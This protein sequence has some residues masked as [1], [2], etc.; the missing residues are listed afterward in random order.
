MREV[1]AGHVDSGAIPG[2]VALVG[3]RG[4]AHVEA[5]GTHEAGGAGTPMRRD[6][7]FRMASVTKP[8]TAAA[9]M[10]LVEECRL[11]L[12]DPV[13]ALALQHRIR[14]ARRARLAGHGPVVRG[15]PAGTGLRSAGHA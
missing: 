5:L 15:V 10:I 2:L 11:R 6:T 1:L 9:V 12:D 3:R 14:R 8:V 13:E 4:E 7:I